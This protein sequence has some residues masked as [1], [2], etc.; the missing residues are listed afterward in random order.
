[1]VYSQVAKLDFGELDIKMRFI[2]FLAI[3]MVAEILANHPLIGTLLVTWGFL[4]IQLQRKGAQYVVFM[5][6]ADVLKNAF[7]FFSFS[8]PNWM[9]FLLADKINSLGKIHS[10]P[11]GGGNILW[12]EGEK[13]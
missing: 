6:F 8:S 5:I 3:I 11:S 4:D 2:F 12:E 1:M 10:T 13:F 7:E 9:K